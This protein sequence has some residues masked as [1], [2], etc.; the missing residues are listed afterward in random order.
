MRGNIANSIHIWT[1]R[2]YGEGF[3]EQRRIRQICDENMRCRGRQR[4][5]TVRRRTCI[6]K[7]GVHRFSRSRD[8][9]VTVCFP[10]CFWRELFDTC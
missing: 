8:V 2:E 3:T 4:A 10:E 9:E 5:L 6:G 1:E 7:R